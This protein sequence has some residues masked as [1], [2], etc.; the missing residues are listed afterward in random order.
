MALT[1]RFPR[2]TTP[3]CGGS[4]LGR[5]H[6]KIDKTQNPVVVPMSAH[7]VKLGVTD[8][9]G[10]LKGRYVSRE[11]FDSMAKEGF[12]WYNIFQ[13][14]YAED[15]IGVCE[16]HYNDLEGKVDASTA[17]AVP[18]DNQVPFYLGDFVNS[19]GSPHPLCPRQT[20]KRVLKRAE[21]LGFFP[22]VGMELEFVNFSETSM[23]L[24]RKPGFVPEPAT[25]DNRICSNIRLADL[26]DFYKAVLEEMNA[27]KVPLESLH[28][29]AGPGMAE[30][31]IT[32]D[33]ALKTA[34]HAVLFK[35]GIREIG[36]RFNILPSFM[37]KWNQHYAGNSGHIHQSLSDGARNVFFDPSSETRRSQ[38]FDSF[39]AGL[40][41]HL[42]DFG[43]LM[44][45][46]INSYKRLV[47]NFVAPV[48]LSW[49][50]G[51]R[52]A[53]FRVISHRGSSTRVET[54]CPG[55]D[56][57]PYLAI[58]AVTAAG[59]DGVEKN[60]KFQSPCFQRNDASH[61]KETRY[62]LPRN[63]LNATQM[64]RNSE[65]AR[66]WLGDK[67]VDHFARSREREID[68]WQDA[69]TDWERARYMEM[70]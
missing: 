65:I 6:S 25:P 39:L 33:D 68:V 20:L 29:E 44:W 30:V 56:V 18:W 48:D 66:S 17:R 49:S 55:A 35:S 27:F 15:S 2:I 12:D 41:A 54:R 59:M 31:S 38:V 57:N 61:E 13:W 43:P 28:T 47:E 52:D 70:T 10:I 14:D 1:T 46:T 22:L 34:D 21:N 58:A 26:R 62:A 50:N 67:F 51:T 63:L 42:P 32:Y 45:P 69:V 11:K 7:S 24:S 53:C 8:L 60:L 40:V 4:F 23:S 37:A 5:W 3:K 36:K 16:D 64:F 9:N 19:D